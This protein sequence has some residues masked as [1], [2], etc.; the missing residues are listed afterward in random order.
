VAVGV[1]ADEP[2]YH[3]TN[4]HR[5]VAG[6]PVVQAPL[7]SGMDPA[8]D[9]RALWTDHLRGPIFYATAAPSNNPLHNRDHHSE[10]G[11][12][13]RITV[14]TG[15]TKFAAEP[16]LMAGDIQQRLTP[17]ASSPGELHHHLLAARFRR[18][19]PGQRHRP[20]QTQSSADQ[21]QWH[22]PRLNQ[23]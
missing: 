3:Q 18:H 5:P 8:A 21:L 20:L 16:I 9:R 2:L 22:K 10:P 6:H 17:P 1:A 4:D 12:R 15:S 13:L 23:L 19:G 7:V 14:R 11:Q